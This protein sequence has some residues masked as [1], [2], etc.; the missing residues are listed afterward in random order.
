MGDQEYN[1]EPF[2]DTKEYKDVNREIIV[3]WIASLVDAGVEKVERLLDIAT[4]I[5]TM[6]Q[7]F[8]EELP[9]DWEQPEVICLD[10]S[11][12]A[13]KQ[14][15]KKLTS[16][17]R[18]L[19]SINAP[20]QE[21]G[22]L[23]DKV[24]VAVWGNGIHNLSEG[25]QLEAVTRIVRNLEEGGWFFFN[26]A[27]YEGARPEGT[28]SFYRYKVKRAVKLLREKGVERSKD[29]SRAE[30]SKFLSKKHYRELVERAGLT[31][32][33]VEELTAPLHQE[34]WEYISGFKNYA[35]GALHGYPVEEAQIALK[36]AVAPA[37][38]KYGIKDK[39]GELYVPRKWLRVSSRL[40]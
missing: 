11:E 5:G 30:A 8:V 9:S 28:K 39:E 40:E 22:G 6:V 33:E 14:A 37:L 7:L 3:S 18:S 21:M 32:R 27:F 23:E 38:E 1:F 15:R 19:S 12:G 13:I 34:A 36:D 29:N 25:E 31:V 24:S 35:M 4:G 26:S 17:V 16:A 2:A 10:K 20:I